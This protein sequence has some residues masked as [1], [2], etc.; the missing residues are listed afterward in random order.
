M[1]FTTVIFILV[2]RSEYFTQR[3]V[4]EPD[5]NE[6]YTTVKF[7]IQEVNYPQYPFNSKKI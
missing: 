7:I 3:T 1:N 2:N 5:L 4:R 6:R